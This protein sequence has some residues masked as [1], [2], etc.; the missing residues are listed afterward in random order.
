M[1]GLFTGSLWFVRHHNSSHSSKQ[2]FCC[3]KKEALAV[4]THA[5]PCQKAQLR[6]PAPGDHLSEEEISE[7]PGAIIVESSEIEGPQPGQKMRLRL[8]KTHFKYPMIRTEEIIDSKTGRLVMRAEMVADHLLVTLPQGTDPQEFLRQHHSWIKEIVR[9]TPGAALY[10][11]DLK[12]S[13]LNALPLALQQMKEEKIAAETDVIAHSYLVP[14]NPFYTTQQWGLWSSFYYRDQN[15]PF[16]AHL[17]NAGCDAENA[18]DVQTSAASIVVAV[19]DSGIRYTHENLV[20]NIW[21]NPAPTD[22]DKK[23]C[24]V[25]QEGNLICCGFNAYGD[26]V[27]DNNRKHI[28]NGNPMDLHGHGTYVAGIIGATGNSGV[29]IAGVAW[30]IQLMGCRHSDENGTI[31]VSDSIA[32]IDYAVQHKARIINCSW[33]TGDAYSQ[34]LYEA[35]QRAQQAGVIVVTAAGNNGKNLD[36]MP[37]YPSCFAHDFKLKNGSAENGEEISMKGLDNIVVVTASTIMNKLVPAMTQETLMP[38]FPSPYGVDYG[39]H[40]VDLAAPGWNIYGP[41]IHEPGQQADEF[42]NCGYASGGGTSAAAPFVTGTLALLAEV[43]RLEPYQE[44][45][46]RLL[47]SVDK[48]PAYEGKVITGGRLNIYQALTKL[49]PPLYPSSESQ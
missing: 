47:N 42:S 7:F 39:P 22:E 4:L 45:I 38:S 23:G 26:G 11:V 46:G 31:A 40:T 5:V 41:Y 27:L 3:Q 17:F 43:Y 10:R 44:L 20:G 25:D 12:G 29:G 34:D 32:C 15:F 30:K 49:Y 37:D 2:N 33:G 28:P 8:L 1:L 21:K 9:V 48:D 35:M 14:N 13:S 16:T 18:W 36:E 19:I 6:S 24:S